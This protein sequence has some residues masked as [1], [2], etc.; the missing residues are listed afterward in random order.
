M[1]G[2]GCSTGLQELRPA[3]R[4][5]RPSTRGEELASLM[6]GGSFNGPGSSVKGVGKFGEVMAGEKGKVSYDD[7]MA[8]LGKIIRSRGA[9]EANTGFVCRGVRGDPP[10]G[11]AG[12][13]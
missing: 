10:S 13:C 8:R 3:A 7:V 9:R 4:N 12:L 11:W 5:P 6:A 1:F 2:Q